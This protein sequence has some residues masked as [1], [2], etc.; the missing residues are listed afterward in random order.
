MWTVLPLVLH[1]LDTENLRQGEATQR[2]M[3][4]VD[5]RTVHTQMMAE[6]EETALHNQLAASMLHRSVAFPMGRSMMIVHAEVGEKTSW[7]VQASTTDHM[8]PMPDIEEN[9]AAV[10]AGQL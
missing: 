6:L 9:T 2:H 1:T 7:P 8:L 5:E 3:A 10:L 4:A